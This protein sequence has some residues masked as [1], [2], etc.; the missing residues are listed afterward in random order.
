[1]EGFVILAFILGGLALF[2]LTVAAW[3]VDSREPFPTS[4][5]PRD[6]GILS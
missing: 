1:M 3:G 4:Q 5:A 2:N 6:F